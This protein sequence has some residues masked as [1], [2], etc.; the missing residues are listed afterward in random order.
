MMMICKHCAAL[1]LMAVAH[2]CLA[3]APDVIQPGLQHPSC[4][5]GTCSSCGNAKV[6]SGQHYGR[7]RSVELTTLIVFR[8]YLGGCALP[9]K[10]SNYV[11]GIVYNLQ[12]WCWLRQSERRRRPSTTDDDDLLAS[13]SGVQCIASQHSTRPSAFVR[14]H[15]VAR[16][17]RSTA[18]IQFTFCACPALP[19]P[20]PAETCRWPSA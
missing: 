19:A 2:L 6:P 5:C 8:S 12:A 16:C 1:L 13:K 18:S 15:S 3:L 17:V 9:G 10:V 4:T 20:A 11:C 14:D 7:G